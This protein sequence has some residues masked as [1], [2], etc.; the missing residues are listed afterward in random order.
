MM[1]SKPITKEQ[2]INLL[3]NKKTD[4]LTFMSNKTKRPFDA[5]LTLRRD[6]KIGFEFPPRAPK[7]KAE[8]EAAA[9]KKPTKAASKIAKIK[10]AAGEAAEAR[11]IA[12]KIIATKSAKASAS[13]VSGD[14]DVPLF[15]EDGSVVGEAPASAKKKAPAKK[16]AKK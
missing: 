5:Y 15:D 13:P 3:T 4:L 6:G 14:D 2:A 16:S 9:P 8:G 10:E 11:P 12:K 1:L 7:V